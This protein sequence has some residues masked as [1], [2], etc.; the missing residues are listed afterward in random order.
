[1]RNVH[2][3]VSACL[4]LGVQTLTVYAFSTENWGRPRVEVNGLMAL[5]A[6]ASER[7]PGLRDGPRHRL[8]AGAD[9]LAPWPV[10]PDRVE[11]L[12]GRGSIAVI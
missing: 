12:R 9:P 5:F 8:G 10:G 1:M 11:D 3:I 4:D 7:E 2:R 6:D